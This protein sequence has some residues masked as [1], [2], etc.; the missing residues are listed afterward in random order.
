MESRMAEEED[1]ARRAM[2]RAAIQQLIDAIN[3]R[4]DW[5]AV[6]NHN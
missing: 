3:R 4:S 5:P 6:A 1:V 2:Y